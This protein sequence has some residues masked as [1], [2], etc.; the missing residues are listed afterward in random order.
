MSLKEEIQ[1][2]INSGAKVLVDFYQDGC[3]PCKALAAQLDKVMENNPDIIVIKVNA[4]DKAEGTALAIERNIR[5]APT[6]FLYKEAELIKQHVGVLPYS[7][8]VDIFE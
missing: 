7:K 2:A 8:I 4:N 6:V 5:S 1:T 3:P